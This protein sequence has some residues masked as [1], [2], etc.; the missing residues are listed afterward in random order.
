MD[1]NPPYVGKLAV[2][3]QGDKRIGVAVGLRRRPP[4][5]GSAGLTDGTG[6]DEAAGVPRADPVAVLHEHLS[7]QHGRRHAAREL[8]A[9]PEAVVAGG[10][11]LVEADRVPGRGVDEDQVGVAADGD[12]ALARVEPEQPGGRL[13]GELHELLDGEP[14]LRD[15]L[16]EQHVHPRLDAVVAAG[17]VVDHEAGQL[18]RARDGEVVGGHGVQVAEGDGRPERVL[19]GGRFQRRVVVVERAVGLGVVLAGEGQVV[20]Q[21]LAEDRHPPRARLRDGRGPGLRRHVHDVERAPAALGEQDHPPDRRLLGQRRPGEGDVAARLAAFGVEPA[22]VEVDDAVVLGVHHH[23]AAR[24]LGRV[25]HAPDHA[26]VGEQVPRRRALG[27]RGEHLERGDPAADHL[28]QLAHRG[29]G[30][31]LRQHEVERVVDVRLLVAELLDLRAGRLHR[32]ARPGLEPEVD[33]GRGAAVR[34]RPRP[35]ERRLGPHRLGDPEVEVHVRVDAAGHHELAAGVQ[36]LRGVLGQRARRRQQ[37]H[38]AVPDPDV[39]AEPPCR[40]HHGPAGHHEIE[41]PDS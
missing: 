39:G 9:V 19:V 10:V 41:H 2:D 18:G 34:R 16:G 36:P 23:H 5:P 21:H 35:V 12:H 31:V 7:A 33:E 30:D 40:R 38:P 29:V 25:H 27:E 15:P 13:G 3:H 8:P 6:G 4:P 28:G 1:I 17:H 37:H 14:V 32:A 11:Q 26:V 22:G 20:V 24:P